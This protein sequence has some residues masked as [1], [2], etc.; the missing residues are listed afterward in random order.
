MHHLHYEGPP[1]AHLH[2]PDIEAELHRTPKMKMSSIGSVFT[3]CNSGV[4]S[5]R[6]HVPHP[7]GASVC[8]CAPAAMFDTHPQERLHER[9]LA[10]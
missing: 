3:A 4:G 1:G 10:I 9:A 2:L 7:H 5:W 8:V 6:G